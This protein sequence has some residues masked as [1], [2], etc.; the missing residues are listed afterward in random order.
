MT[1]ADP[2]YRRPSASPSWGKSTVSLRKETDR[3]LLLARPQVLDATRVRPS[4]CRSGAVWSGWSWGS[5]PQ[6]VRNPS[7]HASLNSQLST[8]DHS[9]GLSSVAPLLRPPARRHKPRIGLCPQHLEKRGAACR[10]TFWR[11][12]VWFG[13]LC[14][15][16]PRS[17]TAPRDARP[18]HGRTALDGPGPETCA[19]CWSHPA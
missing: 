12:R 2:C 19:W 10:S 9:G 8:L 13:P 6:F 1:Q 3:N 14:Y 11:R 7:V 4:C 5:S 18:G 15:R 16:A 17:F